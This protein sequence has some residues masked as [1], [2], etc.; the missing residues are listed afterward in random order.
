[1]HSHT[2]LTTVESTFIGHATHYGTISTLFFTNKLYRFPFDCIKILLFNFLT[3]IFF[4]ALGIKFLQN[5]LFLVFIMKQ[6]QDWNQQT[7][8]RGVTVFFVVQCFFW[9]SVRVNVGRSWNAQFLLQSISHRRINWWFCSRLL[10]RCFVPIIQC[11]R[12]GL[13]RRLNLFRDTFISFL[14]EIQ[15]S[16]HV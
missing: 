8:M 4:V 14:L 15:S 12:F 3:F 2:H 11:N 13:T 1:M 10:G 9:R 5:K 6:G 7:F 16:L